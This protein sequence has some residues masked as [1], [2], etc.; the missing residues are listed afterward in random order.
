MIRIHEE[1]ENMEKLAIL[2]GTPAI[3]NMPDDLFRWPIVTREDEEA[4]L[5]VLRN[6]W[7]SG[8]QITEQFEKEFAAWQGMRHAVA[9][10]NGTL[11]LE[12]AMF[13]CGLGSG[14]EM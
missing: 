12:A 4:V 13:A 11:A 2:G 8:T 1:A 6:S 3:S 10:C 7:Q 5:E 14:D 9:Y